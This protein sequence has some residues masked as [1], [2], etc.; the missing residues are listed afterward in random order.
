MVAPGVKLTVG[1]ATYTGWVSYP[2]PP[3]KPPRRRPVAPVLLTAMLAGAALQWG[4]PAAVGSLLE[5]PPA[6]GTPPVTSTPRPRASTSARPT[7]VQTTGEVSMTDGLKRGVVLISG[8]TPLE[9]VA[10]TGMVISASGEVVTNYH[11]VRSTQKLTVTIASTGRRYPA[12]LVG[13]D[14]TKDVALLQLEGAK[15][16]DVVTFDRD[17]VNLGDVVVAAG[18]ANGQGFVTANRG[19]V[20]ATQQV[21]MVKGPTENDPD[22]RLSGLIETNAPGWPGDS[23]GPMFDAETQVLGMTTAGSTERSDERR[24]YAIPIT[25]AMAVVESV[26]SDDESG[27]VVIGPKAF[28]GISVSDSG[29]AL[30]VSSVD[31]GGPASKAGLRAGDTVTS[32]G[33]VGV[34]TRGELSSALDGYEP[35]ST[36]ELQWR[37]ASGQQRTGK[38][39]FAPSKLN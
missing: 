19:N 36:T 35:G 12:T 3:S 22:E 32:V 34:A 23:G 18:N 24:V 38:V 21:I 6:T 1:A 30:S 20:L 28:L 4:V 16:L 26:R 27:T 17:P 5:D 7:P 14:A 31:T 11:V 29:G 33:G 39:T 10:G 2:V 15:G 37:T 8:T 9:N 13:R 25:Q